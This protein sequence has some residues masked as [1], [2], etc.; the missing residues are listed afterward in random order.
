MF[1]GIGVV[2]VGAGVPPENHRPYNVS[3]ERSFNGG[4]KT[5]ALSF[6][7][8]G[9]ASRAAIGN[10]IWERFKFRTKKRQDVTRIRVCFTSD[11]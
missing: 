11:A 7:G 4:R 9:V 1:V 6:S 10:L 8:V 2:S 5:Y 3:P